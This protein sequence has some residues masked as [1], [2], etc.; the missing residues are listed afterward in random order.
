MRI[1]HL[2][3][4]GLAVISAAALF[5]STITAVSQECQRCELDGE[6]IIAC[7]QKD[8]GEEV[9]AMALN[10][11]G[12]MVRWLSNEE[13]GTW[14]EVVTMPNGAGCLTGSGRNFETIL[15]IPGEPS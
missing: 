3:Y 12:H 15:P 9:V 10:R 4:A 1:S 14:S 6:A 8:W 7:L 11:R 13:T 2:K 5:S